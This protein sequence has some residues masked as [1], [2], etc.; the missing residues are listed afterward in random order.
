MCP[1]IPILLL[2]L[3]LDK[4]FAYITQQQ[5]EDFS[6]DE[7]TVEAGGLAGEVLMAFIGENLVRVPGMLQYLL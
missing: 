3:L 4:N 2:D 6:V 5:A 7:A 1:N